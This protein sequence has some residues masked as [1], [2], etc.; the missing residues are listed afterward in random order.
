[1]REQT[2]TGM[3]QSAPVA[4][5]A[6]VTLHFSLSLTDG[7]V[8]DSNYESSPATFTVGDGNLLPGFEAALMGAVAEQTIDVVLPAAQAFGDVNPANVQT[9]PRQRFAGLLANTTDP[10]EPGTVVSFTDSGGNEIPGVLKQIGELNVV[11]DFNH[12]LAGRD[13]VFKASV[14]SVLAAD[15]Q[16]VRLQG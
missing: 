9:F 2:D 12:P 14:I 11:I 5:G 4:P 8:I 1:M 15:V 7:T 3:K 6:R 16:A 13:I 10:V